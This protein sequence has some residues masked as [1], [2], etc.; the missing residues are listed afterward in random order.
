MTI[1]LVEIVRMTL[2]AFWSEKSTICQCNI[3]PLAPQVCV[4]QPKIAYLDVEKKS[5]KFSTDLIH[6]YVI[7]Q[8]K[9][10]ATFVSQ[11]VGNLSIQ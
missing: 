11:E 9:C 10:M 5:L 3:S 4:S 2:D 6:F 8:L 7:W 1:I